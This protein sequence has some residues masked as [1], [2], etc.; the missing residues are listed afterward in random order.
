[1]VVAVD[2][3][4]AATMAI[5]VIAAIAAIAAISGN[6]MTIFRKMIRSTAMT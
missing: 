2:A 3:Q 5:V 6:N 1:V 4:I